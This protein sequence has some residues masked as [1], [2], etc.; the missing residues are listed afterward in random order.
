M[1]KTR[2]IPLLLLKDGLLKKPVK[3]VNPRTIANPISIVRVFEARQVD[4]LIL[5]D[6]GSGA[7]RKQQHI[8]KRSQLAPPTRLAEDE[9]P[10]FVSRLAQ[11]PIRSLCLLPAQ[12]APIGVVVFPQFH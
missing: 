9:G 6:I 2:V 8:R 7:Q 3:F 10:S 12:G 1:I 5:L 11:C 4:E